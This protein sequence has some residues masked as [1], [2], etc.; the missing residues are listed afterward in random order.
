[1]LIVLMLYLTVVTAALAAAA[2]LYE[3]VALGRGAVTRW[4]WVVA[5]TL[6]V[7]LAALAWWGPGGGVGEILIGPLT[8]EAVGGSAM[9]P[10]SASARAPLV[11]AMERLA[12]PL[13][14]AMSGAL[15]L[16]FGASWVRLARARLGWRPTRVAGQLVRVSHDVG[17]AV[18]GVL[19]PA[20]V[21]PSWLLDAPE[22]DRDWVVRHEREHL[23]AGDP[24]LVFAAFV[25]VM[26]FPWNPALWWAFR[27][28]R[29]AVEVDCDRRVL[30]HASTAERRG[31][32]ELLFR[33]ATR[34]RTDAPR[35]ALAAFAERSTV[36][37]RRIRTMFGF[38]PHL[39]IPA[40]L[41]LGGSA[42]LLL[43]LACMVPAPDRESA[44]G[45]EFAAVEAPGPAQRNEGPG[46]TP[47]TVGPEIVNRQEVTEAL[48]RAYPPLLRD[49]G[50]GGT[51]LVWFHIDEQ[52][53]VTDTRVNR[54]SGSPELDRAALDV[55]GRM[56]FTRALNRDEPVAV[57]V[58]FPITFQV[59]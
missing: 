24:Q 46:F 28:L 2:H 6:P 14:F 34:L 48:V 19:Q 18:V 53:Q 25:V 52:G 47:Y 7:A 37:E 29:D 49:A 58:S 39:S 50:I 13:W 43:G 17:P 40:R 44:T 42:A 27:R 36:L 33:V 12:G 31:Y 16:L 15:A 23:R 1:M 20:I 9:A 32:G 26:A 35:Y 45:P 57:W 22:V 41:G 11:L 54:S 51:T 55:A 56:R 59:R 10:S 38:L 4:A 21:L 8:V 3:R 5:V 30:S